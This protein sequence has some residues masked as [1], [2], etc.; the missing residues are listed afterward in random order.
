[1]KDK[2]L[3]HANNLNQVRD[4][5]LK[6]DLRIQ[7]LEK[8]LRNVTE[9]LAQEVNLKNQE[10]AKNEELIREVTRLK[11]EMQYQGQAGKSEALVQK[12]RVD[13]YKDRLAKIESRVNVLTKEKEDQF[14]EIVDQKAELDRRDRIIKE[15]EGA[16][17]FKEDDFNARMR[18]LNAELQNRILSHKN[19]LAIR[20]EEVKKI[21]NDWAIR[22]RKAED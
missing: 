15:I 13:D 6:V 2:D 10:R 4:D 7:T 12:E 19:E 21:E 14:R 3:Q 20:G 9:S 17:R 18:D 5:K 1:M 16:L 8:E 22:L 11:V